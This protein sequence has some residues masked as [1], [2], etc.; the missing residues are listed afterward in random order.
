[1]QQTRQ[2]DPALGLPPDVYPDGHGLIDATLA[3]GLEGVVAKPDGWKQGT[4]TR[5]SGW[6]KQKHHAVTAM[7]VLAARQNGGRFEAV[8]VAGVDDKPVAW[9]EAWA[10]DIPRAPAATDIPKGDGVARG[11]GPV[12]AVRHL[13]TPLVVSTDYN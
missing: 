3:V 1:M 7:R 13:I 5:S 9:L 8:V 2:V 6:V 10:N 11:H 4:G 12:V